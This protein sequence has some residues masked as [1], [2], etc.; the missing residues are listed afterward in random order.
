MAAAVI[1][2]PGTEHG[3]CRHDCD[4]DDCAEL[5]RVAA[6]ICLWCNN[7]IGYLREFCRDED[8][9]GRWVHYDCAEDAIANGRPGSAPR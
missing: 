4:H 1:S 5:R 7:S 3:P 6:S 8:H 2:R 9:I